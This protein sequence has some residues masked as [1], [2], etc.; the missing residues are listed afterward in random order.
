MLE[1]SAPDGDRG[2]REAGSRSSG[3]RA[4]RY[5]DLPEWARVLSVLVRAGHIVGCAA[6]VGAS[7]AGTPS[8]H[9]HLSWALIAVTG[10]LLITYEWASHPDQ[11]RQA[12]GGATLLKLVLL[13]V[14]AAVPSAAAALLV[15]ATVTSVLGAH[16]PKRFRHAL[17]FKRPASDV[18]EGETPR[19]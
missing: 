11:W 1:P 4:G 6:I 7:F 5:R 19:S 14:A 8:A 3:R 15:V 12:S 16:L 2:R 17:I 10:A 13:V 18:A 9:V